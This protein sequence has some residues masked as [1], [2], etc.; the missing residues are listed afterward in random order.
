MS[1]D[2][3]SITDAVQF[4]DVVLATVAVFAALALVWVAYVGARWL[5][6]AIRGD[7]DGGEMLEGE[8]HD[9]PYFDEERGVWTSTPRDDE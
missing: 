4:G 7:A 5:L 3:S 8:W 6:V 1:I 2:Y 9:E